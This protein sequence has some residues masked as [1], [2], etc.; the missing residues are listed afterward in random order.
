VEEIGGVSRAVYQPVTGEHRF[1]TDSEQALVDHLR[2]VGAPA[3]P[4]IS[5]A[6]GRTERP[7][8]SSSSL[9]EAALMAKFDSLGIHAGPEL[10]HSAEREI[11][12]Q[13][14]QLPT[15]PAWLTDDQVTAICRGLARPLADR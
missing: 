5:Q 6:L 1:I 14:E 13:L 15:Y 9:G 8:W 2:G 3:R 10:V 11:L 4:Y 12:L 7:V